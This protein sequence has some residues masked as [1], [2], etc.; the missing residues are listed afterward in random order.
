[1]VKT[2]EYGRLECVLVLELSPNLCLGIG[3]KTR[4]ILADFTPC[5]GNGEDATI[6]LVSYQS[7]NL[8]ESLIS[9]P[10]RM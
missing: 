4:R 2:T 1:M 6:K 8:V 7:S 3:Q 9:K 10:W 5:I